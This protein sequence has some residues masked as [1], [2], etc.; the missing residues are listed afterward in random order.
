ME[1]AESG[2]L[3][4]LSGVEPSFISGGLHPESFFKKEEVQ[5]VNSISDVSLRS[6]KV[7]GEVNTARRCTAIDVELRGRVNVGR[8]FTLMGSKCYKDIGSDENIFV[9]RSIVKNVEASKNIT[10]IG[11]KILGTV[12]AGEKVVASRCSRVEG[13]LGCSA[14]VDNCF[15]IDFILVNDE[16]SLSLSS[17]KGS[18]TCSSA[19]VQDSSIGRALTCSSN[20]L[21]VES[22]QI[23]TICLRGKEKKDLG[24]EFPVFGDMYLM[25]N[26]DRDNIF[27]NGKPLSQTSQRKCQVLEL[28]DCSVNNII[29]E[30][31]DGEVIID[32]K[33]RIK[34]VVIGGRVVELNQLKIILV[35]PDGI[36]SKVN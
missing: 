18:V 32:Y 24:Y 20:Y 16:L 21:V 7:L 1:P 36:E 17:V 12:S 10:A 33:S 29:F 26:S 13:I 4:F 6:I 30:S 3:V 25:D 35:S 15:S 28:R 9:S 31:G 22:S 14:V 23:D 8:D 2:N 19:F 34:G 5:S 27:H 11:S